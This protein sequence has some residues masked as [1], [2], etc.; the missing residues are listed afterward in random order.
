MQVIVHPG[1]VLLFSLFCR[2]ADKELV[3]LTTCVRTNTD[4]KVMFPV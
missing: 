1:M 4:T 2:R 3:G